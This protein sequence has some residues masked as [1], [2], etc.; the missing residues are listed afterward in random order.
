LNEQHLSLYVQAQGLTA[1]VAPNNPAT[2]AKTL[3]TCTFAAKRSDL[4]AVSK[5]HVILAEYLEEHPCMLG[6]PGMGMQLTT[7]YR[8]VRAR[9]HLV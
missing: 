3:P 1:F 9:V 4:S 7:Y 2:H 5:G 6:Q 8:K